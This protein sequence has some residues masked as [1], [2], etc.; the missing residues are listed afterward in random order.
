[1]QRVLAKEVLHEISCCA[2][3]LALLARQNVKGEKQKR[4]ENMETKNLPNG[5][6]LTTTNAVKGNRLKS[7]ILIEI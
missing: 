3:F 4:M 5:R 6:T 7:L 2:T 1:V